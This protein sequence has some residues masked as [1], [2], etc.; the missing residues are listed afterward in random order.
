MLFRS[1]RNV[2][3]LVLEIPLAAV[4]GR[5]PTL[6]IWA[7]TK[8]P[9][10][11]GPISEHAGRPLRSMFPENDALNTLRPRDHFRVLGLRPD[12]LILDTARPTVY[13]NGRE[14]A[15]DVMDQVN[16]PRVMANDSPY[17]TANDV[18][19]L[20]EFPYLAPPQRP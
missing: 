11:R 18:P 8:V 2:A 9:D 16:D 12:V 5:Q 10:I 1:G 7:T 6:L 15:D 13:P 4:L 14:L 3:A 20:A 17:P 19:F